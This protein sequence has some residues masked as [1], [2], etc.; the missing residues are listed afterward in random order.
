MYDLRPVDYRGYTIGFAETANGLRYQIV[1][2]ST[3]RLA[4][5]FDTY[6]PSV[7]DAKAAIDAQKVRI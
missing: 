3:K 1:D 4:K 2:Q 7:D 5:G 6:Y